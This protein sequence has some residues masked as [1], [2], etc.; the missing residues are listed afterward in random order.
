MAGDCTDVVIDPVLAD[1]AILAK[2]TVTEANEDIADEA[3]NASKSKEAAVR[4]H[5]HWRVVM[6][7]L[8]RLLHTF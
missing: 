8:E 5:V 3:C 7:P 6:Q 4:F 2:K 1:A